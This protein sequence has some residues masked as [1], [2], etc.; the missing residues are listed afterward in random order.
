MGFFDCYV[1]F[2]AFKLSE[3]AMTYPERAVVL[4]IR[5]RKLD[6]AEL[7]S[8]FT[9]VGGHGP[10]AGKRPAYGTCHG[11]AGHRSFNCTSTQ[12]RGWNLKC[13]GCRRQVQKLVHAHL[14]LLDIS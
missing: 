14:C 8:I 1:G 4:L 7:V 10:T 9:F 11:V 12:D 3:L 5:G 6:R 2:R 13:R